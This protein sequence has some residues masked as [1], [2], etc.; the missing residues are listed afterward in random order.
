LPFVLCFF[1]KVYL[2][3][4]LVSVVSLFF[5]FIPELVLLIVSEILRWNIV[6]VSRH[7]QLGTTCPNRFIDP[8]V[9]HL[10]LEVPCF[11]PLWSPRISAEP[12][13]QTVFVAPSQYFDSM[14]SLQ[15]P[16]N[17]VI[18]PSLVVEEVFIYLED[19]LHGSI[20]VHVVLDLISIQGLNQSSI[21]ALV[22]LVRDTW[23]ITSVS[24]LC[25]AFWHFSTSRSIRHTFVSGDALL[26]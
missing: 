22:F 18:D 2:V 25:Y 17:I 11:S 16:G 26:L 13:V 5:Y 24:L 4:P 8:A 23:D 12:V 3:V 9:P 20:Y 14:A 19:S 6:L 10:D 15:L 21:F 1:L 7:I